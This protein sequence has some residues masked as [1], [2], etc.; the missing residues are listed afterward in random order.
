[1]D[2]MVG[3]LLVAAGLFVMAGSL[4]NWNWYWERRRTQVWVDLLGRTGARVLYAL[5]GLAVVVG[6]ALLAGGVIVID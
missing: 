4:F 5:L 1:M 3:Y 2:R 6:G